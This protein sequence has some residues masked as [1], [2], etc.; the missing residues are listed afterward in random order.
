MQKTD[1]NINPYFDDFDEDKNFHRYLFRPTTAVQARELTQLQTMLQNQIERHGNHVFKDGSIVTGVGITYYDNVPYIS[2]EDSFNTNTSLFPEDLDSTYLLTNSTDSNTAVRA[3]IKLAKNGNKINHPE[4][5]RFYLDYI[6]TGT[7]VSNNDVNEFEPG[8]TLYLYNS[9]QNKFGTLNAN[10]LVDSIATLSTNG[11]FTSNGT[12]YCL[13]VSD[14]IIF[15]K[16]FFIKVDPQVIAVRDFSTNVT[17][18]VVGFETKETIINEYIDTSLNDNALGYSN[19]NAPG[20]HRLKLTPTLISKTRADVSNTNFFAI[21]EFDGTTPT[22]QKDQPVYNVLE[23]QLARKTY[24]ESGDYTIYPF[25]VETR[26]NASNSQSF[27]YEISPGVA[28]VRGYR[29]EKVGTTLVEAPRATTTKVSQNQLVTAN[30]G[31]YVVCDEV[32]GVFD[33]EQLAEVTLY[34]TAQ[35]AISEYESISSAPTGSVVGKA[36]I[37]AVVYETGTKGIPTAQYYLYL[38]NIRMNSGKSFSTDVKSIYGSSGTTGDAKADI[39]LENDV[40]VLKDS[41]RLSTVFGTG[42]YAIKRLTDNT[43]IGDTSFIYSQI[44]SGTLANN[45]IVSITLDSV[46][47]GAATERLNYTSGSTLTGSSLDD[48]NICLTANAYTANLTGTIALSTGN[49]VIVGSGTSFTTDLSSNSNIRI[50]ANS[51]QTYVRRVVSITNNTSLTIDASIA[52]TNASC[53]FGKYFVGGTPLPVAN[54]NVT[55]NTSFSANLGYNLDSGSQTVYCYYPVNRNQAVSIPKIINKN[56]FVK[57]DCSN[58]ASNTV[59]PWN[60][61]LPNVHKIRHVYVGTTY[62]NSNPD[63]SS[64][65]ILDDGQRDDLYD[66]GKLI[67]KPEYTSQ[68]SSSTKMLVELDHFTCNTAASVG[69][70]SVESYPID[71]ANTSNTTAIQT[72]EIPF[73][74]NADL[75]NYIDFRAFKSNTAASAT[76]AASATI[77]PANNSNT[78]S[79]AGSGQYT[80][81]PDTNFEADIEYYLPRIDLLTIDPNG[82]FVVNKGVPDNIPKT[83]FVENDQSA[84]VECYVP[85]YPSATQRES[86]DYPNALSTKINLKT[87]RRYTMKDIGALEER[88]K[89][90]EYYTVLNMLEQ[91]ARDMT[92]PD[93]NGLNRFKNGIFA[94]PFNSHNIGDV[95]DFEYKIAIDPDET[96][97]RPYF[98]KHDVDFQFISS[99]STNVQRT[100]SIVT[101]PFT[102]EEYIKQRFATK[103]RN[104]TESVWQWNGTINLYPSYDFGR[105]E[106]IVPNVNINLDLSTPWQQFAQSPFGAIFGDWRTVSSTSSSEVFTDE[107]FNNEWGTITRTRTNATQQRTIQGINVNTL[108]QNIDLGSYVKDVSIQPYMRSKI[109]A[110]VAYNLKPNTTLH[111]FFDDVNVDAYCAPG[112]L[113]GVTTFTEGREDAIV[114]QTGAYGATLVSDSTGFVC[115]LFKIPDQTFRTGD[116]VFQ[117]T[118]VDDLTTGSDARITISKATYTADNIA[119]TRSST[120]INVR[121]PIISFSNTT[122]S[123]TVTTVSDSFA[124]KA[125]DPISQS[126]SIGNLPQTVSGIFITQ[127][128][129]YFKTKDSNLGCS[130]YICEMNNNLPDLNKILGKAYLPASSINVSADASDETVFALEYP[131]YL[132]TN[133]DYCF[134]VLPDGNSPEYN[135]WVGETGGYDV[136]TGEQVYANPY[137]GLMFISAN[138]KSWTPIQKEDIKFNIYRAKFTSLTGTAVFKNENDEYLTVVGFNR[139]NTNIGIEV[140]DIVYTVN[141]SIVTQNTTNIVANTLSSKVSGR[142]QYINEAAGEIWLD[143]STANSTFKFSNTTNPIIAIYRS[144]DTSNTSYINANNLIAYANVLSVDNLKY[145]VVVPKFGVLQPS[146]TTLNYGFKGTSTSNIIDTTFQNVR[147]ESD[148]SYNEYIRHAMSRSNE[149]ASLSSGKS[150]IFSVDLGSELDLVSPVINLSRKSMLFVENLINNDVTNEHT[151]YGN[152]MSK[153]ISKR[154][155]LA[156]G[157]EAE[158]IKVYITATRPPDTDIQI[159]IKFWNNQDPELFDDKVWTKLQYDN[160][161]EFVYTSPLNTKEFRE[162]SFSVPTVNAVAYAAFANTT[163]STEDPLTGTISIANNSNIITGTGTSFNTELSAG[164]RIRVVAGDY[165]AIRTIQSITNSTSLTVDNGLQASNSASLYYVFNDGGNDGIVEYKNTTGSRFVGYKEFAVKIVLLSS[166]PVKVPK[167]NDVRAIALQI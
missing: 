162:Y 131:V 61:G 56:R 63:R 156:D 50:Y 32:L 164:D 24:E 22:E 78:F 90:V 151:R 69:F 57:I 124:A 147:N 153:Y 105:D 79:I 85:A 31:N 3:T 81:L 87:N 2:V 15:Q 1:L 94:D 99:N 41:T 93:T 86:E 155:V 62:A 44:K 49:V 23:Q 38:F 73:Y 88:I 6:Y 82:T 126:F 159:Y 114:N 160:G 14:G 65:F 115:G 8:D 42:L 46:A 64:W 111:A 120:T 5:N 25:Q 96:V 100:G 21:V 121:Q 149:I 12:A 51:T 26:V 17:G 154:V 35:N 48:F 60:L 141:G 146:R 54:I 132:L 72:I 129:L 83:P 40:A 137:Q 30:Y 142:V 67:I 98:N 92:I 119:V 13:G 109:V 108:Q 145:H 117:L 70:F 75:R 43:G 163:S 118:N 127:I 84:V 80:I 125:W 123:R 136:A 128:G 47:A 110:F 102:S 37:R 77:N 135:I 4:T 27:Y 71:D 150:S 11:T 58:N 107:Y 106:D 89:R 59:G 139:A 157:Q 97:A 104:T 52:A 113:S 122:Q 28:Y 16:G 166:N 134:C 34:D 165:F 130:V 144:P 55:S 112:E 9:N 36:N 167:L 152:A 19:E 161:G 116:R 29:I 101:L 39:V 10:N 103:I 95:A 91:Q 76:S 74:K 33:T 140:G 7:S 158:D 20:A 138:M 53:K 18:Y 133:N 148:Y 68:I 66:T 143:S 45:G